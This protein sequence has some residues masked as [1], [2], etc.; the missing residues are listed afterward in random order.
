MKLYLVTRSDTVDYDEC[1][2]AVIRAESKAHA[3]TMALRLTGITLANVRVSRLREE[4]TSS[5]VLYS[6]FNS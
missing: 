2:G 4:G 6:Y 5:V 1:T 3:R